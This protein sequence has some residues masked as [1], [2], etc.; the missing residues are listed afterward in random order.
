MAK[1]RRKK[2]ATVIELFPR[3]LARELGV[4]RSALRYRIALIR[5]RPRPP[6]VKLAL[7]VTAL[8]ELCGVEAVRAA[9]NK[10]ATRMIAL[11]D[12]APVPRS[13]HG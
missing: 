7:E 5:S 9:A 10:L 6:R 1:A 4:A 8:G 12:P 11:P 13:S 3:Q 2:S